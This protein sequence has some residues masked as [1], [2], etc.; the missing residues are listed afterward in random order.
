MVLVGTYYP[1]KMGPDKQTHN[2]KFPMKQ[3]EMTLPAPPHPSFRPNHSPAS[4]SQS[5]RSIPPLH[6]LLLTP[7]GLVRHVFS[8]PG[9]VKFEWTFQWRNPLLSPKCP[10]V[11]INPYWLLNPQPLKSRWGKDCANEFAASCRYGGTSEFHWHQCPSLSYIS[12]A[13]QS[14]SF[15]SLNRDAIFISLS[16]LFL[17]PLF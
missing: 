16:N 2:N 17:I 13:A 9:Y 12:T 6:F 10:K 15:Y 11:P 1:G 5:L 8:T 4:W 3:H 14:G 7:A